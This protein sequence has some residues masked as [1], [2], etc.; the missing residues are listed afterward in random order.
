MVAPPKPTSTKL[1]GN[2]NWVLVPVIED[3]QAPT[4]AELAAATAYDITDTTLADGTTWPEGTT[5]TVERNRRV[6]DT[7]L[8]QTIGDTTYGEVTLIYVHNPQAEPATPQRAMG[9]KIPEG[10]RLFLVNRQGLSK[11]TDFLAGQ[12]ISAIY[13][14][15]C[16]PS[17]PARVGDGPSM[18]S[19]QRTTV[20]VSDEPAFDV[21][22]AA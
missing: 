13:P 14:I 4:A 16:G 18:E 1:R 22:V 2:E 12:R 10:S 5:G 19:A 9:E 21:E 6:G 20:V 7:I 3:L 11:S 8:Y 15:E 17:H